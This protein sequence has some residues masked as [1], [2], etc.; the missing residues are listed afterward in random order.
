LKLRKRRCYRIVREALVVANAKLRF[1]LMEY[2]VQGNHIHMIAEADDT[3]ALSR[4]MRGLSIRVAKRMNALM[5]EPGPRIIERYSL[6]VLKT[7]LAVRLALRYVLNNYRRH[8]AQSGRWCATGWVDPFSSAI[9]FR[10]WI[11][12]PRHGRDPCP[13]LPRATSP[14]RSFL[15]REAWKAHGKID[16]NDVPGPERDRSKLLRGSVRP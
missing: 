11:R 1:R 2:S 12:A 5:R 9:W 10:G 7:P 6:T 14:P 15:L 16:P 4:A 3:Y 13:E 8:A